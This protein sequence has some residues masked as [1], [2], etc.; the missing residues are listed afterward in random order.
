M[1]SAISATGAASKAKGSCATDKEVTAFYAANPNLQFMFV[2]KYTNF[3]DT[4]VIYD[5]FIN[6]VNYVSVDPSYLS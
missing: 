1:N 4:D 2:D 3:S 6:T 5:S